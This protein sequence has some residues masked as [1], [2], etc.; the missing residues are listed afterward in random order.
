MKRILVI[1]NSHI[2]ALRAAKDRIADAYPMLDITY[3]GVPGNRFNASDVGL[4]GVFRTAADDP[5]AR[6]MAKKINGQ[7][8]ID[9]QQFDNVLVVGPRFRLTRVLRMTVSTEVAEWARSN[10][11]RLVSESFFNEGLRQLAQDGADEVA[12]QF[13]TSHPITVA[14]AAFPTADVLP[15]GPHHDRLLAQVSGHMHCGRIFRRYQKAIHDALLNNGL[16]YLPQPVETLAGAFLTD[17]AFATEATDLR[18]GERSVADK[19]HMNAEYGFLLFQA[20]AK[21]CLN[22]PRT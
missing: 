7:A 3:F 5:K 11:E 20:Y 21:E 12:V 6:R 1:G 15:D 4:D 10:G 18:D 2:A 17:S 9:L 22:Q 8:D 13:A 14:A 16:R 19:R